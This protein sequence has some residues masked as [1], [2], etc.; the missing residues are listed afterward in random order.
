MDPNATLKEIQESSDIREKNQHCENLANWLDK[1]GFAP[2][3]DNYPEAGQYF[4]K[5]CQNREI[6]RDVC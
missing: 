6:W 5:F 3:W 1:G 4:T 2:Q